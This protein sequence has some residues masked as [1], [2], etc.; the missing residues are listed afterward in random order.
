VRRRKN[1]GTQTATGEKAFFYQPVLRNRHAI[2]GRRHETVVSQFLHA[3]S[4][5]VFKFSRNMFRQRQQGLQTFGAIVVCLHMMFSNLRRRAASLRLQHGN[6]VTHRLRGM[7]EH[8]TQLTAAHNA[9][10]AF[11]C[12]G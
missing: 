11:F 9:E 8:A 3:V 12:I 2:A 4:G 5:D 1:T 7:R 10:T 6:L